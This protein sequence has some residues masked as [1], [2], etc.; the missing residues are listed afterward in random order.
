MRLM[1][2]PKTKWQKRQEKILNVWRLFKE[3]KAGLVGIGLLISFIVMALAA[4]L[5]LH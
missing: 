4:S 5:L 2:K 1:Q 3:S